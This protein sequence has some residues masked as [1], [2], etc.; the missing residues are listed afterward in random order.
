MSRFF[1]DIAAWDVVAVSQILDKTNES[2]YADRGLAA[3]LKLTRS[4]QSSILELP[5]ASLILRLTT[6]D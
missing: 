2:R 5:M 6:D 3:G 1:I 4:E